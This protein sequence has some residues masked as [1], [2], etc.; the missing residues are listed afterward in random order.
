VH[1]TE[2]GYK[3]LLDS[4]RKTA[5][6]ESAKKDGK[7]IG[8]P[9]ASKITRPE[10]HQLQNQAADQWPRGGGPTF[11]RRGSSWWLVMAAQ[12]VEEEVQE[13]GASPIAVGHSSVVKNIVITC[14]SWPELPRLFF[15]SSFSFFSLFCP[16][17]VSFFC[18]SFL[19]Q[20]YSSL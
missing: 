8:K 15:T 13:A 12:A 20:D 4:L 5:E 6:E 10:W 11:T 9:A 1:P 18:C 7:S 3:Q 17:S 14:S 2:E 19:Y 16:H